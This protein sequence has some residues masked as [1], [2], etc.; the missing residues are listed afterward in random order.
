MSRAERS[1]LSRWVALFFV[2]SAGAWL[3]PAARAGGGLGGG[4]SVGGVMVNVEGVLG[5]VSARDMANLIKV[6][7]QALQ[8]ANGDLAQSAPLRMISLRQLADHIRNY[9]EQRPGFPLPDDVR[10]LAGLQ[11]VHYIFVYP[12]QKD[13][14]LAGPAE[15]WKVNERGEVVGATSGLPTLKLDDLLVALQ[16]VAAAGKTPISCSIDPTPE[17]VQRVQ[18]FLKTQ[19]QFNPAVKAG[20]E[21]S[22]GKQ[23]ITVT[24]VPANC[25]FAYVML[26]ADYRMKRYAMGLDTSPVADMPSYLELLQKSGTRASTDLTPRW[27]LAPDYQPIGTDDQGL[28]WELRPGMKC[29][30]EDEVRD[31]QGRV[32]GTGK[33]NTLAKKWADNLTAKYAEVAKKDSAFADLRNCI[34]LAVAAALIVRERLDTKAG[35]DLAIFQDGKQLPPEMLPTPKHVLTEVS[36]AKK[37]R[38]WLIT[39]SGG[40]Q[41]NSH[42]LAE[43]QTKDAKVTQSRPT[44]PRTHWWWQ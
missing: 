35:L 3:T 10:Y 32:Q 9:R 33:T 42:A 23:Q 2:L 30:T 26:A 41:I 36:L 8:Q 34:D 24:G 31:A 11:R 43:K 21:R 14:V 44:Q 38:D 40:V 4:G 15:G 27:W 12:E 1:S 19:K 7:Q 22:L 16:T 5:N 29:L 18:A 13:I 37:Q 6:R 39:A 20:I 28:A 25:R 17:G